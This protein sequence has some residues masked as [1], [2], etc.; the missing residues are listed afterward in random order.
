MNKNDSNKT[1]KIKN[2]Q[3]SKSPQTLILHFF[4][5]PRGTKGLG[6]LVCT[7]FK[8]LDDTTVHNHVSHTQSQIFFTGSTKLPFQFSS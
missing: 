8:T 7:L 6:N 4:E 1:K 2:L 5:S 3:K